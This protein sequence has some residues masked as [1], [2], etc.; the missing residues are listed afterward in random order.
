LIDQARNGCGEALGQLLEGCRQ[1]LLLVTNH[2]LDLA[3]RKKMGA[4]DLVQETFLDAQ[5][6]FENFRGRSEAD[7]LG[8][9]RQ[10]LLNNLSDAKRRYRGT[11][12]RQVSREV[13][14]SGAGNRRRVAATSAAADVRSPSWFAMRR[15]EADAM[16]GA[17]QRLADDHRRVI[18]LRNLELRSFAEIASLMDR[19][20]AAVRKLWARAIESLTREMAGDRHD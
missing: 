10:I 11:A 14:L 13:R 7:L 9:L 19:S 2:E 20:E 4:S 6:D 16:R 3:L 15:E 8:W 5:R 17:I 18:V 1:Y 12:K